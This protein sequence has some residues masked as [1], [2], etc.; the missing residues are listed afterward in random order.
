MSKNIEPNDLIDR[1]KKIDFSVCSTSKDKTL[2]KLLNQIEADKKNKEHDYMSK[3]VRKPAFALIAV[4][5]I[6]LSF[7]MFVYGQDVIRFVKEIFVGDHARFISEI[8]RDTVDYTIP[9]EFAGKVY[10]KEGNLLDEYPQDFNDYIEL[11]GES[12][13]QVFPYQD[14]SGNTLLTDEELQQKT[15]ERRQNMTTVF[16]TLEEADSY[17]GYDYMTPTYLPTGYNFVRAEIYNTDNGLPQQNSKYMDIYYSNGISKIGISLIHM[18]E[19]TSFELGGLG[20]LTEVD[21]NGYTAVKISN[22][23]LAVEIDGIMYLFNRNDEADVKIDD[24]VS[25]DEII[26]MAKSLSR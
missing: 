13:E 8:E 2:N 11:Y 9:E 21:I 20:E 12:G 5:T 6:I 7:S 15:A 3:R 24:L 23:Q 18:D 17:F 25:M 14:A 16:E 22:W 4:L 10:D 19:E 1:Y 26:L